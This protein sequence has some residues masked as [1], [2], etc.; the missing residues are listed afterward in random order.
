M[1]KLI[2]KIMRVGLPNTFFFILHKFHC[3]KELPFSYHKAMEKYYSSLSL[4]EQKKELSDFYENA[5]GRKPDLNNPQTF[6]EKIQWMKFFDNLEIKARLSDKYLAPFHV[7]N[8]I[9][10]LRTVKQLGVW[11]KAEEIKFDVLPEKFVLKCNHGSAMNIIVKDKKN[12]NI[13]KTIKKLNNWLKLDYGLMN[14]MFENQYSLIERKIIAE[15]Y[16]EE[17]DG[18]LHDFKFHCFMGEPKIIEYIG[19]R[20]FNTH[21]Y[22][23]ALLT[24]DWKKTGIYFNDD[25]QYQGEIE[26]PA[27]LEKMIEYTKSMSKPFNYVRIDFYC[28]NNRIYFGEFTFTPDSG[29]MK[30]NN[31]NTDREWGAWIKI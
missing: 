24:P 27:Q 14:G 11:K 1:N 3:M 16:I 2:K 25:P 6:T 18:N 4:N 31:P 9:P 21:K 22:K 13:K 20:E 10:E 30:F 7:L 19:D 15:T 29:I 8:T 12:L 5:L 26:K 17:M 23:S 28:I